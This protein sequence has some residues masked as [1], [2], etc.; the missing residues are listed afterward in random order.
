MLPDQR[1]YNASHAEKQL[2]A[3]FLS[4]HTLLQ[5]E[6][7]EGE[8]DERIWTK[9][10]NLKKLCGSSPDK[11]RSK[12]TIYVRNERK[13]VCSDCQRLRELVRIKLG[14]TSISKFAERSDG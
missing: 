10:E 2:M 12:P 13:V 14:P 6:P 7:N 3:F 11:P 5:E 1:S 9:Y 8:D 4:K